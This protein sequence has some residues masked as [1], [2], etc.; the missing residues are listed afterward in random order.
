MVAEGQAEVQAAV[1]V[2]GEG[3]LAVGTQQEPTVA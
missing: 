2:R 1:W 3:Q